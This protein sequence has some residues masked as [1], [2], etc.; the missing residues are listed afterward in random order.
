MLDFHTWFNDRKEF[1]ASCNLDFMSSLQV[2]PSLVTFDPRYVNYSMSSSC[3][4][5]ILIGRSILAFFI[6]IIFVLPILIFS[7][8]FSACSFTAV[9]LFLIS[10]NLLDM[11]AISSAYS[12]SSNLLV[13]LH[14]FL[15]SSLARCFSWP[16]LVPRGTG[17][18]HSTT[19]F[20]PTPYPHPVWLQ[21]T[22]HHTYLIV[23]V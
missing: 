8:A 13:N 14:Q 17:I 10:L 6:G 20:H 2:P 9:V 15:C 21:S 23:F 7:P 5:L 3:R 1:L 12:R 18:R 22:A 4:L 16:N 19:L 11:S